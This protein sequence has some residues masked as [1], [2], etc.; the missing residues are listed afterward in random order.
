MFDE[1]KPCPFCGGKAHLFVNNGV[2]VICPKCEASTKILVD[3]MYGNKVTGN[4]TKSVIDA[5]NKR[6]SEDTENE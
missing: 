5:W 3:G 4:A 1:L 2:R 6:F